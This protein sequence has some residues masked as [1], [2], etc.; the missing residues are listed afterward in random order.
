MIPEQEAS[1]EIRQLYGDIKETLGLPFVNSDYEALAKWPS[2]FVPAWRDAKAWRRREEYGRLQ[3]QLASM[4]GSAAQQA[5]NPPSP[6][7]PPS[8][9]AA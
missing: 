2:F 3:Q 7:R 6:S 1:G 5:L 4:A 9:P 8:P